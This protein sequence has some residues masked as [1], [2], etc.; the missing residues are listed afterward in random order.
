MYC[1]PFK[2]EKILKM[3]EIIS[4]NQVSVDFR[5]KKWV[6]NNCVKVQVILHIHRGSICMQMHAYKD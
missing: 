6:I 4:Y 2:K 3:M 5:Y 1:L